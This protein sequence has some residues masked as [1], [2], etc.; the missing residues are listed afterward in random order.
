MG[1]HGRRQRSRDEGERRVGVVAVVVD[2][3]LRCSCTATSH[4]KQAAWDP[5]YSEEDGERG[6]QIQAGFIWKNDF[7]LVGKYNKKS[8]FS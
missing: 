8:E 2:R 4:R 5:P 7:L 1:I 3:S 6:E